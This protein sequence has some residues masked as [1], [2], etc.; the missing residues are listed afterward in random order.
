MW[1]YSRKLKFFD[2]GYLGTMGIAASGWRQGSLSPLHA[3]GK[4]VTEDGQ[5]LIVLHV[6]CDSRASQR[7]SAGE[8]Q[9]EKP[10]GPGF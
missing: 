4:A 7:A 1:K 3:F 10:A 6:P 2:E 5:N 9:E 8:F